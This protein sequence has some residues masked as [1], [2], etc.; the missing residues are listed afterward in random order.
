MTDCIE[1]KGYISPRHGYGEKSFWIP[2]AKKNRVMRSH[3]W[4]WIQ[5]HGEIPEGM[6]VLH[7][8]D[9]RKCVN[10]DHLYLGTH[11]D[12]M[13]DMRVRERHGRLKM[14]AQ[15]VQLAREFC[16]R[17]LTE[18]GNL[19]KGVCQFLGRWFGVSPSQIEKIKS[20]IA[21]RA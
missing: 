7:H 19:R 15:D 8:C 17:H 16:H 9:N 12:N 20:G 10:I 2:E 1:W 13:R 18:R 6:H 3:R 21:R 11:A 5:Q 4:T 14:S